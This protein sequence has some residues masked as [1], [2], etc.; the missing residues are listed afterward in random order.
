M[1]RPRILTIYLDTWYGTGTGV[2][3]ERMQF[4]DG[5]FD[6]LGFDEDHIALEGFSGPFPDG[7][8]DAVFTVPYQKVFDLAFFGRPVIAW[9]S[10]CV[11]RQ[12]F[13][14]QWADVADLIVTTDPVAAVRYGEKGMLSNWACRPEWLRYAPTALPGLTVSFHGQ[15]YGARRDRLAALEAALYPITLH[16]SDTGEGYL[17]PLDYFGGMAKS[18]FSLCLTESSHGVRQMKSR[19]FEPQLFGSILVTEPVDGLDA[20]WEPGRECVVFQ[21]PA[22]CVERITAL[23]GSFAERTAMAERARRRLMAEHTYQKR[24]AAVFDRLGI[25]VTRAAREGVSV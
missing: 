19:L 6:Q 16:A 17:P 25:P 8:Y 4:G 7:R 21:S 1:T 2:S 15:L 3:S 18:A 11:W 22:E 14:K 13:G 9:M 24:F 10:D 23:A 20:F 5:L 12:D